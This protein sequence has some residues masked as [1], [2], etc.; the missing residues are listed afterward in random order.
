MDNICVK[1]IVLFVWGKSGQGIC[2]LLDRMGEG[3]EKMIL[4]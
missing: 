2:P 4:R 3:M 1:G